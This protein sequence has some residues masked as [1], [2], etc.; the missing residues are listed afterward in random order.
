M[1]KFIMDAMKNLV[2]S[3]VIP[4][5]SKITEHKLNGS[6]YYDWHRTILFYLQSTDMDD[7][8]T[9]DPPEDEKQKK[10]WL[11]DDAQLYLQ[12]KIQLRAR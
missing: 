10:D 5:A 8:M 6:N 3:N 12:I 2:I 1:Y 9:V 4:L 7:H 11:R